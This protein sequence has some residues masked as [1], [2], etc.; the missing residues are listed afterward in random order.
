LPNSAFLYQQAAILE[1]LH[2]KGSL[3]RAQEFAQ[4]ARDIDDNNHIYIH[5]LA[6]VARRQANA[7]DSKVKSE[8]FRAQ[9]R[10][11]LNE[12]WLKDSRK[13]LTF[14]KLLIDEAVEALRNLREDAKDHEIVEFDDKVSE[15]AER[16]KRAQQDFPNEAEF[17][18]AE[19]DLWQRL[20]ESEQASRAFQKAIGVRPKNSG[21]FARLSRIQRAGGLEQAAEK[22]LEQALER[23]PRDKSVHLQMALL[24]IGAESDEIS[25]A[26]FHF[27]SSFGPGDH[28][29]DARFYLAEFLF[30]S[31]KTTECKELFDEIDS[32]APNGFR[33]SAPASDDV[34]TLKLG[35]YAGTIESVKDRYF[36]IR[37]GGYPAAI[38]AHMTSLTNMSIDELQVGMAVLFRV[39]F[40]RRGPV[41]VAVRSH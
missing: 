9:S 1:Y 14:C 27:K 40:N 20:G 19:G 25:D 10:S 11:Y 4:A 7:T 3:D 18:S 35:E 15:A 8:K 6:E 36:F 26:E 30:L 24:K 23:F 16:L 34:I 38:F 29:F 41:A 12:I 28:N 32:K 17:L 2:R 13:D 31:G 37:F 39:R 22:T 33:K 5:T 21:A